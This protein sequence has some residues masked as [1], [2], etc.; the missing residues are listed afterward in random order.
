VALV[1]LTR[2]EV[3]NAFDRELRCGLRDNLHS[4]GVDSGVR[5]VV[6]TGAGRYFSSGADLKAGAPTSSETR[7]QLL[8]EYGP[9]LM[10]IAEMP[11]PVIAA[12]DGPAVGIGLAYALG[13]DLRVMAEDAFMQAPF[14]SIG[15]IPDGGLSWLLPRAMGYSRAFEAVVD[16]EAIAAADCLRLGL[17]NRVVAAGTARE[18]ALDWAARLAARPTLAIAASKRALRAGS[19]GSY[20]AALA[21][22]AELQAPLVESA[23]CAEGIAAF[24]EKRPPLFRGR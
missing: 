13:C 24:L 23:D 20:E 3:L 11:K 21:L 10:A 4:L 5:A 19:V 14:N 16:A 1:T 8:D 15:L 7:S 9:G 6:L 17:A 2:P 12:L 18:E 22:E